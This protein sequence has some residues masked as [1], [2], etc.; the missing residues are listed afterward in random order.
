MPLAARLF[1]L[2]TG[3]AAIHARRG[4]VLACGGF[5]GDPERRRELF[6]HTPTGQEH[7]TAAPRSNTGDGLRLGEQAGGSV[8]NS[9]AAP[10]AGRRC[11]SSRI[12]TVPLAISLI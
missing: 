9:L 6:P 11:R 2:W 8:N 12:G 1:R 10:A 4:V 3:E 7:W 5:P